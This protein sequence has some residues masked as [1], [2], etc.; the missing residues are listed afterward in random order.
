MKKRKIII[1]T[2][3]QAKLLINKIITEAQKIRKV[4]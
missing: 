1:I 4:V 2:E 3:S